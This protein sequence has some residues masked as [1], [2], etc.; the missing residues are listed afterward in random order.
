MR[1]FLAACGVCMALTACASTPPPKVV[2]KNQFSCRAFSAITWAE[3][4]TPDTVTQILRHNAA[5]GKLCR[6]KR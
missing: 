4:D 2:V 1:N 5:Y 6:R 3:A